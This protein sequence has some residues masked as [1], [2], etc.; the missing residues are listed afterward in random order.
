MGRAA[1]MP[2]LHHDSTAASVHGI[3]YRAPA[4]NTG[5]V[6]QPTFAGK[7]AAV[8]GDHCR[9]SDDQTGRCALR[10]ILRHQ[11]IGKMRATGAGARQRCHDD[12]VSK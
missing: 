2:Q 10:V 3:G 12:A 5:I 9:L 6:K 11:R 1:G 4:D 8:R 7:R